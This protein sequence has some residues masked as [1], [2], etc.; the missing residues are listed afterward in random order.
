[1]E[2]DK[3][4]AT[5]KENV[6]GHVEPADN[7]VIDEDGFSNSTSLLGSYYLDLFGVTFR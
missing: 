6:V 3:R 4:S 2:I 5:T 1:M 7:I